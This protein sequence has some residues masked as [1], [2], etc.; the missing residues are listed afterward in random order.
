MTRAFWAHG[1]AEQ[2]CVK[3]WKEIES[4][5]AK[6]ISKLQAKDMYIPTMQDA[7]GKLSGWR[8]T[9]RPNQTAPL[10][11]SFA[12]NVSEVA[13]MFLEGKEPGLDSQKLSV[14][15]K[16]TEG[17]LGDVVKDL[18]FST[19]AGKLD[20]LISENAKAEQQKSVDDAAANLKAEL[21]RENMDQLSK[22]AKASAEGGVF[23]STWSDEDRVPLNVSVPPRVRN[24]LIF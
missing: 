21:S 1:Y 3:D 15:L 8:K 9:L 17:A 11:K 22:V 10:E 2:A 20:Q 4:F 24:L 14:L 16:A 13:R 7:L 12:K 6:G 23:L 18:D 5:L 19:L